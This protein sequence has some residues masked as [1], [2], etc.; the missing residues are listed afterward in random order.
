MCVYTC[1]CQRTACGIVSLPLRKGPRSGAQLA[2]RLG[3]KCLDTVNQLASPC[4]SKAK[5]LSELHRGST[6]L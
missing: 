2:L 5:Y 6:L 3:G 1:E 4:F